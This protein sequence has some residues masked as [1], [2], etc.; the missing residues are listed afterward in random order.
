MTVQS[1]E[2]R[3]CHKKGLRLC[4]GVPEPAVIFRYIQK[5]EDLLLFCRSFLNDLRKL[6]PAGTFPKSFTLL[7]SKMRS[8]NCVTAKRGAHCSFPGRNDNSRALN[9]APFLPI[10][11]CRTAG[12]GS[13]TCDPDGLRPDICHANPGSLSGVNLPESI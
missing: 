5:R 7:K 1:G 9:R 13:P 12:F 3:A 10:H 2:Y 11:A 8:N 4:S 6:W